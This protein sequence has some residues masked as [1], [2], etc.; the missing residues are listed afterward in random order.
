MLDIPERV[1]FFD[2]DCGL[3]SRC[4]RFAMK[5]DRAGTL[6]FAPIGGDTWRAYRATVGT[7]DDPNTVHLVVHGIEFRRSAA[8]VRLLLGCRGAWPLLG[9]LA[10][11][12]PAP[13]RD[14]AYGLVARFR[15]RLFGRA[16]RCEFVGSEERPCILP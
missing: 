12:V 3:C 10:W 15:Y 7:E 5:R 2:G 9:A 16:D 11:V 13:V 4:V 14:L 6:C 8:I 1:L